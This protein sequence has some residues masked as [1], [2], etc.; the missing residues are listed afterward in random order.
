MKKLS[1]CRVLLV[2]DAKANL[3]ILVRENLVDNAAR[4]EAVLRRELERISQSVPQIVRVSVIGLMS[5]T[6]IDASGASDIGALVRKIR[7]LTYENGLLVR[8]NPDG[9]R[10]AAF[11][12]PPLMVTE[13]DIVT[14]VRALERA[15]RT[16]FASS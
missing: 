1:D 8:V 14:G 15:L 16:A 13:D 3:D 10:I 9:K 4:S 12:Y 11:F 2:D 7:H 6:E 5:S